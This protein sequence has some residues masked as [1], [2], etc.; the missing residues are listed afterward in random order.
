MAQVH[1]RPIL[2]KQDSAQ[3]SY[4][5]RSPRDYVAERLRDNPDGPPGV[6][7]TE[8]KQLYRQAY[9]SLVSAR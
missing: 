5:G 3:R 6:D 2:R 4:S 7:V 8:A 1:P 9:Q